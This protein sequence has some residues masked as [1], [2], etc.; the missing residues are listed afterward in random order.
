MSSQPLGHERLQLHKSDEQREQLGINVQRD[1]DGTS[2]GFLSIHSVAD[3]VRHLHRRDERHAERVSA[4]V[5][6]NIEHLRR[7]WPH[8]KFTVEIKT[9]SPHTKFTVEIKT[10]SPRL[11]CSAG[12]FSCAQVTG[13]HVQRFVF[14]KIGENWFHRKKSIPPRR[15]R[16]HP[17]TL[18]RLSSHDSQ[19]P[20]RSLS[21]PCQPQTSGSVPQDLRSCSLAWA[22]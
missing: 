12:A 6:A 14:Q 11:G 9:A 4:R 3:E 2:C 15:A 20:F 5:C 17:R 19:Q 16:G 22:A 18:L 1:C 7:R 13:G 10:A 8:T 21:L